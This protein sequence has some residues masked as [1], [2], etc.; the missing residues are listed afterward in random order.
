VA[1]GFLGLQKPWGIDPLRTLNSFEFSFTTE[2]LG[3]SPEDSLT[4]TNTGVFVAPARQACTI[5]GAKPLLE[6]APTAWERFVV[7]DERA[8]RMT[9]PDGELV[10]AHD[11]LMRTS[12]DLCPSDRAFWSDSSEALLVPRRVEGVPDAING[13]STRRFDL[14]ATNTSRVLRRLP[15]GSTNVALKTHQVWLAEPDAWIAAFDLELEAATAK[16]FRNFTRI[17]PAGPGTLRMSLRISRPD[18]AELRVESPADR[19][20]A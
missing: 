10:E 20:G 9:S 5:T 12:R 19:R 2:F 17:K 13:I 6:G 7:I 18:D 15:R 1:R 16:A 14:A 3:Q 4:V 8:W 11:Q